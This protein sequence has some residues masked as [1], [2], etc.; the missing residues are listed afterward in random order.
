ML[1]RQ[2]FQFRARPSPKVR[3]KLASAAGSRRFV[4]NRALEIQ[5]AR[6]DKGERILSYADLCTLL[7]QWKRDPETAWLND[8]PSQPLQQAL[9]DL[10]RALNDGLSK[11]RGMPHFKAKGIG[12]SFRYPQGVKVDGNRIILPKIGPLLFRKSREI[13]GTIKNVTLKRDGG[14]WILSIQTEYEVPDPVHPSQS[15]I[16]IDLGVVLMGKLSDDTE[17]Q[18]LALWRQYGRRIRRAQ[19]ALAR[20]VKGSKNYEKQ[21]RRLNALWRRMR[22]VRLDYLHKKTTEISKSHAVVYVEDLKV[23]QMTQ[24]YRGTKE[25]PGQGVQQKA[26]LNRSILEQGWYEFRRQLDYKLAWQGGRLIAV[27]PRYTSQKCPECGYTASSNR[28]ER[29]CFSCQQCGYTAHADLVGARNIMA[30]GRTAAACV[31]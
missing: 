18:A 7:V 20:K 21:R 2:S 19:R 5:R 6:L 10:C 29:A 15:E 22:N 14:E 1:K 13:I 17:I 28:P 30:V 25:N 9:K 11:K 24:S 23:S 3:Q 16:A 27:D 26:H 8:Q 12:D 4:W 31:R